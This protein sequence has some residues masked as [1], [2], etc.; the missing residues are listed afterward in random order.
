MWD[1]PAMKRKQNSFYCTTIHC[2]ISL[3]RNVNKSSFN[4]KAANR[5]IPKYLWCNWLNFCLLW[6]WNNLSFSM[7]ILYS[8]I[9][10]WYTIKFC[11]PPPPSSNKTLKISKM[12]QMSYNF[13]CKTYWKYEKIVYEFL[14][15]YCWKMNIKQAL[16]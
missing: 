4:H 9:Q 3:P 16:R 15:N 11:T 2:K 1:L 8:K 7:A 12:I 14:C 10:L 5:E 6:W 13:P